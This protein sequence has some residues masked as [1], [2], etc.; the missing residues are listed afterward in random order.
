MYGAYTVDDGGA[1][2]MGEWSYIGIYIY[3]DSMLVYNRV[4]NRY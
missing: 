3:S 2:G 1:G 4:F